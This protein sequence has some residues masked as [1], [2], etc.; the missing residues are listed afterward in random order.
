MATVDEVVGGTLGEINLGASAAVGFLFPLS[1]QLDAMLGLA[2]GPLQVDLGLQLN[3]A[4][5]LQ[6]TLALNFGNPLAALQAA[7]A[8]VAQLQ[9]ALTAALSLPPVQLT[10]GAELGASAA[11]AGALAA[12]LGVI[13]VAVQAALRVKIPAVKSAASIAAALGAGPAM[14][15]SFDGISDGTN[16]AAVGSLIQSKFAAGL[17]VDS[18]D[19]SPAEPVSGIIILTTGASVYGSLG[20]IIAA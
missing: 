3:A 16:L 19:I 17:S 4:L 10:L 5:G 2:L 1:A 8:A 20:V 18:V 14:V 9:A 15:L 6:A 11:L 13:N 12:K 7:L